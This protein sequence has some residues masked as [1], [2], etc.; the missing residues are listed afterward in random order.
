M[1]AN[2]LMSET[3]WSMCAL[4]GV[5]IRELAIMWL[6]VGRLVRTRNSDGNTIL[7]QELCEFLF[8]LQK[9]YIRAPW[10]G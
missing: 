5:K 3:V 9:D 6:E 10:Q 1:Y 7:L 8:Q 2:E 4:Y